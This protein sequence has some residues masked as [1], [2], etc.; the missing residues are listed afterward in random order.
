MTSVAQKR[1]KQDKV[2][3]RERALKLY[4]ERRQKIV[5]PRLARPSFFVLGWVLL[6]ALAALIGLASS[7]RVPVTRSGIGL[8]VERPREEVP[9]PRHLVLAL[10]PPGDAG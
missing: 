4:N 5:F 8:V 10:L 2:V 7:T 6:A 3:F 9:G 1:P